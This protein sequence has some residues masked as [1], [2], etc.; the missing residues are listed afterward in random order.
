M[1]GETEPIAS[2]YL[3]NVIVPEIKTKQTRA[4]SEPKLPCS[5]K[6]IKHYPTGL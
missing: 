4:I 3:E 1:S 2:P 6:E 5:N